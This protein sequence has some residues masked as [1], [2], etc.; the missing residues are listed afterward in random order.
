MENYKNKIQIKFKILSLFYDSFDL[1]FMFDQSKNPRRAL[2]KKI[3]NEHI[4]ILDVCVG[5]ANSAIAVTKE[6]LN[7][8]IIGI[9]LSKEMI[10]VAERKVK[11]EK[12]PNI[13]FQ[14][15]DATKMN[16]PNDSFNI[17][18]VS[19]GLHELDYAL[20]I[21][22]LR[23]MNRVLKKDGKLYIIDYEKEDNLFR[24]IL[25]WLC[26]KL[27]EPKHMPEFLTYNWDDILKNV[28]FSL[29]ANEKQLFSKLI[30]GTKI[31]SI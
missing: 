30:S 27:F 13:S 6:N 15:M 26:L 19:F 1:A 9:D 31:N 22:I 16:F 8:N 20:M 11:K 10:A 28:G 23:E 3:P 21:K 14:Q 4:H 24:R 29:D 12:I 25:L 2:A 7:T 17:V 18:M 5:T